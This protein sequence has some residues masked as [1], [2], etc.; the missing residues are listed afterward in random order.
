MLRVHP[1]LCSNL[2]SPSVLLCGHRL[3]FCAMPP[4]ETPRRTKSPHRKAGRNKIHSPVVARDRSSGSTSSSSRSGSTSRTSVLGNSQSSD[5]EGESSAAEII[6]KEE[7][8]PKAESDRSGGK[9][10][11][12]SSVKTYVPGQSRSRATA[13][14]PIEEDPTNPFNIFGPASRPIKKEIQLGMPEELKDAQP[15]SSGSAREEPPPLRSPSQPKFGKLS[16]DTTEYIRHQKKV[17]PT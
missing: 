9:T 14:P 16:D 7:P 15:T 2:G 11:F 1:S 4:P 6:V 8:C 13:P 12:S 5:A 3:L 17:G 10:S